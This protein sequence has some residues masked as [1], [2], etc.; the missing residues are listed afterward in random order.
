MSPRVRPPAGPRLAVSK[1]IFLRG[2]WEKFAQRRAIKAARDAK[3]E[4]IDRE[5]AAASPAETVSPK[6]EF[7]W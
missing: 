3:Q 7:T 5:G 1:A 6:F 4:Q 2:G